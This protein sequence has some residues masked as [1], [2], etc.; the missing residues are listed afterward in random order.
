M[1]TSSSFA[2]SQ[3]NADAATPSPTDSSSPPCLETELSHPTQDIH[4]TISQAHVTVTS[5]V[6][7]HSRHSLPSSPFSFVHLVIL[8]HGYLGTSHD[9]RLLSN[10]LTSDGP[11]NLLILTATA[12]NKHNEDTI[13][14]TASRLSIEVVTFC[15]KYCPEILTD[16][17]DDSEAVAEGR[18]SDESYTAQGNSTRHSDRKVS[19]R[20]SGP[21]RG[22]GSGKLEGAPVPSDHPGCRVSFIG[23]SMGGLV[24]RKALESVELKPMLTKLYLYI[25]LATPHLGKYYILLLLSIM[26]TIYCILTTYFVNV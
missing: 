16:D 2:Y 17:N 3:V 15:R 21:E 13:E 18:G 5:P 23:H 19:G 14:N 9:M 4:N 26:F 20:G 8:Q 1:P 24:I 11:D 6:N 12:N 22:R 7:A 25:S 10:I